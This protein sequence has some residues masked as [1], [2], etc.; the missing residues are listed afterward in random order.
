MYP[1]PSTTTNADAEAEARNFIHLSEPSSNV[2]SLLRAMHMTIES[3][4]VPESNRSP[5]YPVTNR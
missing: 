5:V 4:S 2:P 3:P 1:L